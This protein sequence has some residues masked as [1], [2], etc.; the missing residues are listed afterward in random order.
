MITL[1][2]QVKQLFGF[3]GQVK[4]CRM[5]GNNQFAFVEYSSPGVSHPS[6]LPS[7]LTSIQIVGVCRFLQQ[8][9]SVACL[10]ITAFFKFRQCLHLQLMFPHAFAGS[11]CSHGVTW[12][13]AW[14]QGAQ[15]RELQVCARDYPPR[16]LQC[17]HCNPAAADATA[18]IGSDAVVYLGC[19]GQC[20]MG[21]VH[22]Q[23]TLYGLAVPAPAVQAIRNDNPEFTCDSFRLWGCPLEQQ[24]R[25]Q[26]RQLAVPECSI[27]SLFMFVYSSIGSFTVAAQI[28]SLMLAGG[29]AAC[30]CQ[31]KPKCTY[32][33]HV[34]QLSITE[35]CCFGSCCVAAEEVWSDLWARQCRSC[36]WQK[37]LS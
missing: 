34:C 1:M 35:G 6:C 32:R 23:A 33:N 28:A 37:T 21:A 22:C 16:S 4:S 2:Q 15:G 31:N 9:N 20:C 27:W 18:A 29:A 14:R 10:C 26:Q 30:A 13:N 5:V 11:Q 36:Y 8:W 7:S 17:I 12:T 25:L 24:G 3:C 19:P